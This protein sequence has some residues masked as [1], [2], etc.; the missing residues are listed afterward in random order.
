MESQFAY[1][2][3]TCSYMLMTY[4]LTCVLYGF[5]LLDE[6]RGPGTGNPSPHRSPCYWTETAGP[7]QQHEHRFGS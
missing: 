7:W 5:D 1:T 4:L 2:M 6:S 3:L